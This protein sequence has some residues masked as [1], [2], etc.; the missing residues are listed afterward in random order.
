MKKRNKQVLVDTS[1]WIEFFKSQSKI[2]DKLESLLKEESVWVCGVVL[3]E[4]VQG[5]KSES[6]KKQITG[7][8]K[9]LNYIEMTDTLWQ[10]AGEL[11]RSLKTRGVT[12]PF[13]DILIAAIALDKNLSVFTLDKYFEHIPGLTIL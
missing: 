13:S 2:G 3:F 5:I 6:E 1:I 10:K 12:L 7:F 11:S 4:L 9:D 8:L